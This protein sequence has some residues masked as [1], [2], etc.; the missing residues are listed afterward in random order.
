[1]IKDKKIFITFLAVIM[2][3]TVLQLKVQAAEQYGYEVVANPSPVAIGNEVTLT[4][5]LTDY[6]KKNRVLEG[7]KLILQMW[8]TYCMKPYALL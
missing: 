1:M 3:F 2:V 6:T 8:M 7:F 4:I 5:R